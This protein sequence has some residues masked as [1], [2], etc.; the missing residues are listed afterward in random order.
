M[1]VVNKAKTYCGVC[2]VS[3]SSPCLTLKHVENQHKTDPARQKTDCQVKTENLSNQ[4][5]IKKDLEKI[6]ESKGVDDID[7]YCRS[8]DICFAGLVEYRTHL[9]SVHNKSSSSNPRSVF[10]R[11][12]LNLQKPRKSQAID[13]LGCSTC[14]KEYDLKKICAHPKELQKKTSPVKRNSTCFFM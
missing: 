14:T 8:C 3:F 13:D 1:T 11:S 7:L 2:K 5:E 6:D 10:T 9:Q 12:Q 4:F